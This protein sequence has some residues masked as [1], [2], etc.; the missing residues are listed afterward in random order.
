MCACVCISRGNGHDKVQYARAFAAPVG[1]TIAACIFIQNDVVSRKTHLLCICFTLGTDVYRFFGILT[2]HNS[3]AG[4]CCTVISVR[5]EI[6][7]RHNHSED[8]NPDVL[9]AM[10]VTS[11][12]PWPYV[13]VLLMRP[14]RRLLILHCSFACTVAYKNLW[15]KP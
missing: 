4:W 8:V 12:T 7:A 13:L 9:R 2:W 1:L 5:S 14:L 3:N 10:T 6:V 15:S 11:N